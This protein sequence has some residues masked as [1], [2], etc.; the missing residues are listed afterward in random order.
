MILELRGL[1][2]CSVERNSERQ[3]FAQVGFEVLGKTRSPRAYWG[4]VRVYEDRGRVNFFRGY[5]GRF[6]IGKGFRRLSLGWRWNFHGFSMALPVAILG[7]PLYLSRLEFFLARL[8]VRNDA[9][10]ARHL[11]GSEAQFGEAPQSLSGDSHQVAI[12]FS[13]R[14]RWAF[15]Y[16]PLPMRHSCM[17]MPCMMVV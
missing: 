7:L 11:L 3:R 12:R 5:G 17:A 16:S 15:A 1:P 6:F 2:H 13:G 14:R 10:H 4:G 8:D 9:Q